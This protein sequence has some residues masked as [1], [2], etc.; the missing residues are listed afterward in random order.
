MFY[1]PRPDLMM[2][3]HNAA[4][5]VFNGTRK[6]KKQKQKNILIFYEITPDANYSGANWC[7]QAVILGQVMF[8]LVKLICNQ[9]LLKMEKKFPQLI[10]KEKRTDKC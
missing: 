1:H 8:N 6:K 4:Q 9:S 10:K 7:D 2:P 5:T 3:F